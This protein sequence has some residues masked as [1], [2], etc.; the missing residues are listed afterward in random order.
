MEGK[1]LYK[2]ILDTREIGLYVYFKEYH[3]IRET[4]CFYLCVEDWQLSLTELQQSKLLKR[5]HK[6]NSRFAF[7]T[8]EKALKHLRMLKEKQLTHIKRDK[9]KLERFLSN[10]ETKEGLVKGSRSFVSS[11]FIFD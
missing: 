4:K 6:T 1:I 3:S 9:Q 10:P 7:D 8:K 2:A 5:I 11:N